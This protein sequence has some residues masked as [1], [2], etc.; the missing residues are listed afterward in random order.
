MP[1]L[2]DMSLLIALPVAFLAAGAVGMTL[3]RGLIWFLFGR[4]LETLL[5]TWGISMM[6]Q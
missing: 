3:E 2:L 1:G 6:L 4:P 5:M